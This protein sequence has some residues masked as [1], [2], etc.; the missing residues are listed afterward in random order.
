MA[1]EPPQRLKNLCQSKYQAPALIDLLTAKRDTHR[2]LCLAASFDAGVC[3]LAFSSDTL[4]LATPEK[5]G[6]A[7]G[8]MPDG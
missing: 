6:A 5:Y 3:N 4:Y 2:K 1:S 7:R 8:R